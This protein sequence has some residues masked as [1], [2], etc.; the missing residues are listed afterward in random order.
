[1]RRAWGS[2]L[3]H[4][5]GYLQIAENYTGVDTNAAAIEHLSRM[6]S[7]NDAMKFIKGDATNLEFEDNSC[8]IVFSM[9]CF[10]E[11]P[12]ESQRLALSEFF[13]VVKPTGRVIIADP[14]FPSSVFQGMFDIM[15]NLPF[16]FDHPGAVLR[17]RDLLVSGVYSWNLSYDVYESV[18]RFNNIDEL[19]R[20]VFDSFSDE[21]AIEHDIPPVA[22]KQIKDYL[23]SRGINYDE[24]FDVKD[25]VSVYVFSQ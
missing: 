17:S 2:D 23:E 24:Q 18:N 25:V 16:S 4:L 9:M 12:H 6:Y 13:R 7:H 11:I 10:H 21:I 8:N 19:C 14:H 1:M 20:F 22:I 15:H 3:A 5:G